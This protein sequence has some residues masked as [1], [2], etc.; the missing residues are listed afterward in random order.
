MLIVRGVNVFPT[1]IEEILLQDPHLSPHYVLELRRDGR[2]DD[3]TVVSEVQPGVLDQAAE[4]DQVAAAVCAR[5]KDLVG[6]SAGVRLVDPGTIERS[7]GK[8]KRVVDLRH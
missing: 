2:L 8:A 3:L 1:Q 6:V 5:I 7:L 4:R